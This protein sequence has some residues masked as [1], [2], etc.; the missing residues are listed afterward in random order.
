MELTLGYDWEHIEQKTKYLETCDLIYDA[1]CILEPHYKKDLILNKNFHK[2]FKWFAHAYD[3][4]LFCNRS[5]SHGPFRDRVFKL[6][7]NL[8][9]KMVFLLKDELSTPNLMCKHNIL[10]PFIVSSFYSILSY[11][12]FFNADISNFTLFNAV[13]TQKK[14]D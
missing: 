5:R 2:I 10:D 7:E 11:N 3:S 4:F 6:K 12:F 1:I 14:Y 8:Y 13:Y 9:D